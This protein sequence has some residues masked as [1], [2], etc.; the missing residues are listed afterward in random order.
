[1]AQG[2]LREQRLSGAQSGPWCQEIPEEIEAPQYPGEL[3]N[4]RQL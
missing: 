1:M 4:E 3:E 2:S